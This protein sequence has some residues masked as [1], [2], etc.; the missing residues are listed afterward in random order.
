ML[1]LLLIFATFFSY[2]LSIFCIRKC[3]DIVL[4][5]SKGRHTKAFVSIPNFDGSVRA[6]RN[7]VFSAATKLDIVDPVCVMFHWLNVR[8]LHVSH[9]PYSYNGVTTSSVQAAQVWIILQRID[10]GPM[11]PFAFLADYK[12]NLKSYQKK[13]KVRFNKTN[14]FLPVL[15]CVRPWWYSAKSLVWIW[16]RYLG[17]NHARVFFTFL[18]TNRFLDA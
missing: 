7:E 16:G 8:F 1:S 3:L 15:S 12:R 9:I 17:K 5:S 11:T 13:V 6:S 10:T 2:L 4:V 18:T 14:L